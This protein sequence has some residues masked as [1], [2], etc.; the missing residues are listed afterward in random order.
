MQLPR[1]YVDLSVIA[2]ENAATGIQRVVRAVWQALQ[3]KSGAQFEVVPVAATTKM[4]YRRIPDHFLERPLRRLPWHW[5]RSRLSPQAGDVFLGLDLS[6]RVVA[7]NA[8]Q[9]K[10][11]QQRG[12]KLAFMVYDLLPVLHPDWFTEKAQENFR[13][14]LNFV[15]READ[16]LACISRSVADD[17]AHWIDGRKISSPEIGSLRLG[18]SIGASRPSSGLPSGFAETLAWARTGTC[19]MMVGTIEPR[20]GHDEVLAA[21]KDLWDNPQPD[22]DYRLLIVGRPG[23][24]TEALQKQLRDHP[25]SGDRLR[26][27]DNASDEYLEH[28]YGACWG[29]IQ[30]SR[31][32][33]FGLPLL[34]AAAHAKPVLARDLPVFREVAPA[35]VE[36]FT[37]GIA[38]EL[39]AAL[40]KWRATGGATHVANADLCWSNTAED[41]LALIADPMRTGVARG[42]GADQR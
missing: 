12:V 40:R 7:N 30:A 4:R 11:W 5:G 13:N 38:A 18:A 23:W 19:V 6:T 36:F 1:L 14:W 42:G 28:L 3:Q 8:L 10:E 24:K 9:L 32:E 20:K 27:I 17:L 22:E 26:W 31:G 33:G 29:L 37:D 41:L 21:F 39:A 25:L 15:I 2:R 35:G 16:C 34:E